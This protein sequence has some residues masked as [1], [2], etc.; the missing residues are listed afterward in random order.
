[1]CKKYF[2]LRGIDLFSGFVCYGMC[3]VVSVFVCC[4]VCVCV[5]LETIVGLLA[6]CMR[7]CFDGLMCLLTYLFCWQGRSSFPAKRA[8]QKVHKYLFILTTQPFSS[9]LSMLKSISFDCYNWGNVLQ[10]EETTRALSHKLVHWLTKCKQVDSCCA[11]VFFFPHVF[12]PSCS[13]HRHKNCMILFSPHVFLPP[14]A[15]CT[16][17]G[18]VWSSHNFCCCLLSAENNDKFL[19]DFNIRNGTRLK[20]DDFL[21]VYS[22]VVSIAHV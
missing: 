3:V 22:L 21:Q 13:V 18:T 12:P 1:M 15:K 9:V 20:C 8:K 10:S 14:H 11:I 7:V 5:C 19:S 4:S 6:L 17:A 16:G 2:T